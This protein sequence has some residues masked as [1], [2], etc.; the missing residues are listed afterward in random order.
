MG[1]DVGSIA[2]KALQNP[3]VQS[4]ILSKLGD[5]LAK[6]FSGHGKSVSV[7]ATE[8]PKVEDFPDDKI[9]PA[10]PHPTPPPVPTGYTGVKLNVAK[11]QYN[12]GLFPEQYTEDNPFGL[13]RPAFVP[14]YNRNSKIWFNATPFKGDHAV[15]EDEG[16]T[17]GILWEVVWYLTYNGHL[18]VLKASKTVFHDTHN[19]AGRPI[20][21][22]EGDS[23]G[24]GLEAWDFAHSFLC[25]IQVG[26]NEGDYSV[27]YEIPKI[28]FRSENLEFKVS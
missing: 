23:V 10:P 5:L 28:G 26:E 4:F 21:V 18:T 12:R 20:Q 25:Q 16:R 15:E 24:C 7:P 27:Y 13:Y 6:L 3:E 19:G 8:R 2:E 9:I 14:V 1:I 22:V 11:A 17:D